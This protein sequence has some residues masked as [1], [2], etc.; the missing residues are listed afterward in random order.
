MRDACQLQEAEDV[1]NAALE[2]AAAANAEALGARALIELSSLRAFV[3]SSARVEE[4]RCPFTLVP[5]PLEK[6]PELI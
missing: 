1:L 4:R 3:D 5:T 6:L 2:Q